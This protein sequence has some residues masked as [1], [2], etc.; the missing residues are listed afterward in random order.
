MWLR[1]EHTTRFAY[2]EAIS[3]AYTE[4]RLRPQDRGGQRC[5]AFE[6][7]VAPASPRVLGYVDHFG[8]DVRHFD[9]LDPHEKLTVVAVSDVY[10]PTRYDDGG[11]RLS[12]LERHDYLAPTE[13]APHIDSRAIGELPA[14]EGVPQAQ[15]AH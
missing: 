4:L 8:N 7:A 14:E 15:R 9:V 5:S 2:D 12:L 13:Y 10:T 1:V 3:D 11:A 6:V